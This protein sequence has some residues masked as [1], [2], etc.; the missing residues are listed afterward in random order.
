MAI[1]DTQVYIALAVAL[2]PGILAWRL[3]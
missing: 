3:A 1:S 2:I